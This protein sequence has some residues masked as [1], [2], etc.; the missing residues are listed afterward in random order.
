[1]K[2][3]RPKSVS[4]IVSTYNWPESLELCLNSVMRQTRLPDEVIVADDGSA[5]PTREL[6]EHIQKY[7]PVKLIHVWHEDMGFRLAK[8]RNKAL[9]AAK[10]NYII[11]IDHD[12]IIEKNFINDHLKAARP[13]HFVIGSRVK[14]GKELSKNIYENKNLNIDFF[15]RGIKN[16]Y[17]VLRI[18]LL[19]EFLANPTTDVHKIIKSARGCNMGFWR[20]DLFAVNGYNQDLVG[21]GREDSE[22]AARL[23]H[24]GKIKKKV[25]MA[26][27]QFHIYHP[28][29]DRKGL[30]KN[31]QILWETLMTGATVCENGI[32]KI[33]PE[34]RSPWKL[35]LTVIIP[36]YN[37]AQNIRE[38]IKS[39]DFA[40][41]ILVVDSFSTDETVEIARENGA[42]VI[43][44]EYVTPARQKNWI[45]PQAKHKW[46]LLLDADERINPLLRKEIIEKVKTNVEESGFWIYRINFFQGKRVRFSGWQS[47]KVIRLIRRDKCRYDNKHVH[48]EIIA[49][50]PVGYLKNK[51]M[52]NTYQSLDAYISKLNHYADLQVL[53]IEDKVGSINVFHLVVKPFFRLLHHYILRGGFLDG[54][55]GLTIS[56][57]YAYAVR[58]RYLK[59]WYKRK[60]EHG[61]GCYS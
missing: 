18:P 58:L 43:Q 10:S 8:I 15:T 28:E 27:I 33:S 13:N 54:I 1:M 26:G 24:N 40:E 19:S 60:N 37:E 57:L 25:K 61:N 46:V 17:N 23:I 44:H 32:E 2:V 9:R 29:Y 21:W 35:A 5:S 6:V 49:E 11:Q 34:K 41:E 3:P 50:G 16:H 31:D 22:L 52:H 42:R 4:L 47:D 7:S 39:A 56:V 51:L 38:A 48:E 12:I 30:N 53:D 59:L 20:A 55:T 14:L 36:T 45:I